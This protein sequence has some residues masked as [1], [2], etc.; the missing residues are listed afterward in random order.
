ML[1]ST[2]HLISFFHFVVPFVIRAQTSV[3]LHVAADNLFTR[4]KCESPRKKSVE[5]W[6]SDTSHLGRRF[7]ALP[8]SPGG[9]NTRQFCRRRRLICLAHGDVVFPESVL[10]SQASE[11]RA[12][13]S[14]PSNQWALTCF[15]HLW[16]GMTRRLKKKS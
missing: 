16:T 9:Q 12:G 7:F 2:L 13:E 14:F 10:R 3:H 8:F 11:Q 5:V 4:K 1:P 6:K 15:P